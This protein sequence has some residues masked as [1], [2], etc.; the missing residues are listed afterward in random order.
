MIVWNIGAVFITQKD[1]LLS[2]ITKTALIV[3]IFGKKNQIKFQLI[4]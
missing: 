2:A 4:I 1:Y 3:P